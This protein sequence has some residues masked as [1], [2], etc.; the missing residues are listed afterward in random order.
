MYV[1]QWRHNLTV[2]GENVSLQ[3]VSL[4]VYMYVHMC[5]YVKTQFTSMQWDTSG[6][7]KFTKIAEAYYR[8]AHG[9]I[10]VFSTIDKVCIFVLYCIPVF[11]TL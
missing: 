1:Q 11:H 9:F 5:K 8:S 6:D 10:V 2:N 4:C 3:I 7:P